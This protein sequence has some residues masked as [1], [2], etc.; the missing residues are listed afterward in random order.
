[1]TKPKDEKPKNDPKVG[2]IALNPNPK[3]EFK[4]LGGSHG[5]RLEYAAC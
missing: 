4:M 1:M 3:G 2:A 5:R